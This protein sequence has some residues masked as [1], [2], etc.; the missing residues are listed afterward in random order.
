MSVA[1]HSENDRTVAEML[2][3][4]LRMASLSDEHRRGRVTQI[5]DSNSWVQVG[6]GERRLPDPGSKVRPI[7]WFAGRAHEDE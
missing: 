3:H 4:D 1:V 2:L 7:D 6:N 5:V